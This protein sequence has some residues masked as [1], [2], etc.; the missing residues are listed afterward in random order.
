MVV[1]Q[2]I[3]MPALTARTKQGFVFDATLREEGS[4]SDKGNRSS[5][6]VLSVETRTSRCRDCAGD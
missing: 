5:G 1:F 3:A 6:L 2:M 4:F